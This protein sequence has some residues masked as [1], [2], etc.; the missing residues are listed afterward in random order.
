MHQYGIWQ[1]FYESSNYIL[2]M[3]DFNRVWGTLIQS[4]QAGYTGILAVGT[5]SISSH[6]LRMNSDE[7]LKKYSSPSILYSNQVHELYKEMSGRDGAIAF[8]EK[9]NLLG[10]ELFIQGVH[11]E[12]ES[13]L[14][15][16]I[17]IKGS[18]GAR[19]ITALYASR[20]L[21]Y[22]ICLGQSGI[23]VPFINEKIVSSL[24]YK[25]PSLR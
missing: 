9:G 17:C 7:V 24:V 15:Q 1:I 22:A 13:D 12:K 19:H 6:L 25:P 3:D 4:S 14:E 21:R 5:E 18:A 16:I 20:F 11:L 2:K 23:V 10:A 8:D